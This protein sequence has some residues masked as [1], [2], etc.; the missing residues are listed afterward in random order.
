SEAFQ[1][2]GIDWFFVPVDG[3]EP[4]KTGAN[5]A[6][7]VPELIAAAPL[8]GLAAGSALNTF[9]AP[10]CWS[11]ADDSVAFS[12]SAAGDRND[13]WTVGIS[14]RTGKV[15]GRVSR[16]TT[17]ASRQE[18][19]TRTPAGAVAF[20]DLDIRQDVWSIGIDLD[21]STPKGALQRVTQGPARREYA[22]LSKNGRYV[23][24]RRLSQAGRTAGF[25]MWRRGRSRLSPVRRSCSVFRSATQPV[26]E[27]HS[28]RTRRRSEWSTWRRRVACRR[29][30]ARGVW[31]ATT[32]R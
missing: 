6:V 19:P 27:L 21:R 4:V 5:A 32:G 16:L 13:L 31:A 7:A 1:E 29:S 3:G 23:A 2:S 12:T 18:R 26:R 25:A 8:S 28:R 9:P 10:L 30:C 15:T 22:A 11:A 24:S 20:T 14:P 17:R